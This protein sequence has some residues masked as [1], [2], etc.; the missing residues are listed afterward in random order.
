MG[1]RHGAAEDDA[2]RMAA[3]GQGGSEQMTQMRLELNQLRMEKE[4]ALVTE[5][6]LREQLRQA[7]GAGGARPEDR[8]RAQH[9]GGEAVLRLA[10][11]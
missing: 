11:V 10:G 3:A 7:G 5:A 2:A 8:A 9:D 4:Q 6:D 1:R